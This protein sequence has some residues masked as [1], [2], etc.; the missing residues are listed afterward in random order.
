MESLINTGSQLNIPHLVKSLPIIL[1]QNGLCAFSP[2]KMAALSS[3]TEQLMTMWQE[4]LAGLDADQLAGLLL[5]DQLIFGAKPAAVKDDQRKPDAQ[6]PGLDIL[7]PGLDGFQVSGPSEV[8]VEAQPGPQLLPSLTGFP[9][10]HG[11]GEHH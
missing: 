9:L 10:L 3:S 5:S 7:M 6:F 1:Q 4:Q 8:I 11:I 2:E